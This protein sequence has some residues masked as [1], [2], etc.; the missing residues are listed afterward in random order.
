MDI[1]D[2]NGFGDLTPS[3]VKE[4][5]AIADDY[6]EEAVESK[7]DKLVK[8]F[9]I[10]RFGHHW[11]FIYYKTIDDIIENTWSVTITRIHHLIVEKVMEETPVCTNLHPLV[12]QDD[13]GNYW[14]S[15]TDDEEGEE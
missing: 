5:E 15:S 4:L 3:Q 10:S 2:I 6:R 14:L 1:E 7:S 8:Q 13:E 12:V 9:V 11:I